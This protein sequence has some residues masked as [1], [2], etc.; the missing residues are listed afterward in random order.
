MLQEANTH[1]KS[2]YT[3]LQSSGSMIEPVNLNGWQ[4]VVSIKFEQ[5][6]S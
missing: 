4:A 1:K 2:K 3:S 5:R 6:R